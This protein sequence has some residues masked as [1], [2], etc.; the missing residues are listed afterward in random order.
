MSA[1]ITGT[2]LYMQANLDIHCLAV[3]R[4]GPGYAP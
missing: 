2:N 3:E 4:E 1:F